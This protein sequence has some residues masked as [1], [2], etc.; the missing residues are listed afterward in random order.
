[1]AKEKGNRI[2]VIMNARKATRDFGMARYFKDTS[3]YQ[4]Q[5]KHYWKVR[6]EEN[7][8]PS[9]R[10]MTGFIKKLSKLARENPD[11]NDKIIG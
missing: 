8:I 3:L 5:K 9:W 10:R 2:Q 6:V 1:M 11:K 7:S 4:K